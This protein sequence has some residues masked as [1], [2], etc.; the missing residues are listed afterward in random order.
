MH[1]PE[2]STFIQAQLNGLR[3]PVVARE[4]GALALTLRGATSKWT[5]TL[6]VMLQQQAPVWEQ[7]ARKTG[8]RTDAPSMVSTAA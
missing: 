6:T 1:L 2:T 7:H 3:L 8:R 5:N 4:D